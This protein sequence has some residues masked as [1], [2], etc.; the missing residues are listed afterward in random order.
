VDYT[1][2]DFSLSTLGRHWRFHGAAG[3]DFRRVRRP[4]DP[5]TLNRI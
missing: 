3:S 5:S 2:R 1:Q 4:E